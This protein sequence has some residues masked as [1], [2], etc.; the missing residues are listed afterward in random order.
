MTGFLSR[1]FELEVGLMN[2]RNFTEMV[3]G[4]RDTIVCQPYE[5]ETKVIDT[6]S[7]MLLDEKD[8]ADNRNLILGLTLG[9]LFIV[10]V[11]GTIVILLIRGGLWLKRKGY[12]RNMRYNQNENSNEDENTIVTMDQSEDNK[13]VEMPEE[14]TPELLQTLRERLEDPQTHQE[15]CEMIER[16]YDMFIVDESYTNNNRQEEEA[17]LYEELGNLQNP[18]E[19]KQENAPINILRLMEERFN[20][21]MID[22]DEER[23]ALVGEYSEPSD[24]AVHLYSEVKQNCKNDESDCRN[25]KN[26]SMRSNASSTMAFRPLP[27]KPTAGP[28]SKF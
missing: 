28:S 6:T 14:L 17:H 11:S 2:M 15:A 8:E 21:P 9:S 18:P 13:Q 10:A 16:L 27:E 1:C 5:G 4:I 7:T 22:Q 19:A 24:A 25:S 12:F 23:P 26:N 20:F 3:C